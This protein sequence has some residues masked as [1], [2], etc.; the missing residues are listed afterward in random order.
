M[1]V[2]NYY[3]KNKF[4]PVPIKFSGKKNI[5]N[6]YLK[7]HNLLENH[8]NIYL[9]LLK[10]K[11]VLE[12]GCNGAENACLLAEYGA[13]LYLIEPHKKIHKIIINNFNK[14]KKKKNIKLLSKKT[15]ESFQSSKKFEVIIAEGFLNTLKKRNL[16]FKK[17]SKYLVNGGLFIINYDDVY[18][19]F[20][21]YLKSYTL[22]K[23]CH[24]LNIKSDSIK[25]F[26]IAEKLFKKEFNKLNKSRSFKSWWKDQLIN[27]YAAKTWSFEDLINLANSE[28]LICYSTSPTFNDK[29]LLR[30]YKDVRNKD[31]NYN[32]SNKNYYE[33]WKKNFLNF[34]IGKPLN[35]NVKIKNKTLK[36]LKDFINEMNLCLINKNLDKN[37]K[38]SNE[39]KILFKKNNLS[40][41]IKEIEKLIKLLNSKD[42]NT[43]QIINF[44]SKSKKIKSTW[45]N[46]L[47]YV[48][49]KKDF[50]VVR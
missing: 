48:V 20:F 11:N 44:Y 24:K 40:L 7:R 13:N 46:L 49:F 1:S 6:H 29:N 12:F 27:P 23:I 36:K 38:I 3:K 41:Y 4:N 17:I 33:I 26:K 15:L 32:L 47:H 14:I 18:G 43:K 8:L 28:K 5:I 50:K 19:G 39:I 31:F 35:N 22:I 10:N 42:Q 9:P 25:G 16:Y 30:W 2:L 45:G 37:L 21:E 34:F